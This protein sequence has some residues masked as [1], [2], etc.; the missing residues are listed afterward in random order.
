MRA[1]ALRL[2]NFRA[3]HREDALAPLEAPSMLQSNFP[4]K[5][6]PAAGLRSIETSMVPEA[7]CVST[8][9]RLSAPPDTLSRPLA[10]SA[11]CFALA[12]PCWGASDTDC[13]PSKTRPMMLA[14]TTGCLRKP[15][16]LLVRRSASAAGRKQY[17]SDVHLLFSIDFARASRLRCHPTLGHSA[18]VS[19]CVP[20][21]CS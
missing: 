7:A 20:C 21:A 18:S 3:E 8:P 15:M 5:A 14:Y 2:A 19:H 16:A 13:G 11:L 9:N 4:G 6:A 12:S 10:A 1:S 17:C